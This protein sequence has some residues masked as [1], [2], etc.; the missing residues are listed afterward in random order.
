[1]FLDAFVVRLTLIP[2]VMAML[3]DRMWSRSKWFD[4]YVPDLDIEGTALESERKGLVTTS[5]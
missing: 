1:M 4:R 3:G 2:A 5:A